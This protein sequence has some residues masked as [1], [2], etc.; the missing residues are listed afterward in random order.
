MAVISYIVITPARILLFAQLWDML[1]KIAVNYERV[2]T[3]LGRD[4]E[5]CGL[6]RQ[7]VVNVTLTTTRFIANREMI[8][9]LSEIICGGTFHNISFEIQNTND[10]RLEMNVQSHIKQ[11]RLP[12]KGI[13]KKASPV[14]QSCSTKRRV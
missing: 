3:V 8:G 5:P 12:R 4:D 11:S 2:S 14:P 1:E 9:K 7:L 10:V 13:E 6:C